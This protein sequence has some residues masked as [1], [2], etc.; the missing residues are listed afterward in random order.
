METPLPPGSGVFC[1]GSAS[2]LKL[3]FLLAPFC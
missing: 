3:C 2:L 1:W